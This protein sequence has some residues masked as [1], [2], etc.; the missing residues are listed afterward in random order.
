M[1]DKQPSQEEKII[2]DL[3]EKGRVIEKLQDDIG[4]LHTAQ[5]ALKP[6]GGPPPATTAALRSRNELNGQIKNIQKEAFIDV[7]RKSADLLP[8]QRN[9]I[10]QQAGDIL[11]MSPE[12]MKKIQQQEK[13]RADFEQSKF[14]GKHPQQDSPWGD[15]LFASLPTMPNT[16][17][18]E[19]HQN[20]EQHV[21]QQK[22]EQEQPS[23]EVSW[24]SK[25]LVNRP[26][27]PDKKNEPERETTL[28]DTFNDV[29]KDDRE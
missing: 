22:I 20:K 10:I 9:G 4:K 19:I 25:A 15:K 14:A 18:R 6:Q 27:M 1:D 12:E 11:K 21:P 29:A 28:K 24:L 8:E 17:Q 2:L 7:L 3:K 5:P 23:Q 13:S 26:Q 16:E